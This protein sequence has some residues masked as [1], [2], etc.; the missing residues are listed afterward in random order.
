MEEIP[1]GEPVVEA[2]KRDHHRRDM[3]KTASSWPMLA[4]YGVLA[5]GLAVTLRARRF[6]RGR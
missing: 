1:I 2:G 3:P 6:V 5:L 4:L